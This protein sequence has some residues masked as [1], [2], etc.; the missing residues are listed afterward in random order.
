ME[1]HGFIP[2]DKPIGWTSHDVVGRLRR[3][4]GTR[5]IGH[6][7]TLDP[8]ASGVLVAGIGRATRFLD[9]VQ[10]TTKEY[11]AHIVLGVESDS[12]DIDGRVVEKRFDAFRFQGTGE[13]RECLSRFVGEVDQIPPKYSAIKQ[14]G[15]PLHRRVRR[16]ELVEVPVRR[17]KIHVIELISYDHPDLVLSIKCGPGVYIR[18]LARDIGDTLGCGAYL[19]HL[20]RTRVG[21]FGLSDCWE[22]DELANR[23]FPRDWSTIATATDLGIGETASLLV[24]G[25]QERAWYH[26]RSVVT[27]RSAVGDSD[28]VRAYAAGGDFAGL[29]TLDQ[30]ETSTAWVRP[31]IVLAYS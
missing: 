10:G 22:L 8:A 3:V 1:L 25:D 21:V 18:S 27:A 12:A 31:R 29:G 23:S 5:R 16:G 24:D 17:V 11:V 4:I 15:Q 9:C 26:G 14:G 13:L 20:L 30:S 19:H 7:G 2:I 6:A 28:L